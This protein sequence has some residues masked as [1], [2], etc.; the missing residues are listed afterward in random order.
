MMNNICSETGAYLRNSLE[1]HFFD[2]KLA[3][4]ISD[5]LRQ[6]DVRSV[7]DLG[8]G[9][10][11]YTRYLKNNNFDCSG[12]DGNPYT[13]LITSGLCNTLNLAQ[14]I[15]LPG[16]D[17]VVCLEVG[18]HIPKKFEKILIHNLIKST[19]NILIVSWAVED[20]IGE[21][22]VNCRN[23]DYIKQVFESKGFINLPEYDYKLRQ[24]STLSWFKNT[25]MVFK[26]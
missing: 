17:A 4:S 25:I 21:G 16:V 8:C 9:H 3:E 6:E 5:V 10:G 11:E 20:Q 26:K 14:E 7:Y 12:F 19:S 2:N 15:N 24:D 22:H 1:G 13:N 23:N 18:E